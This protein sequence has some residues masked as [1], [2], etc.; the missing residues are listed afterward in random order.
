MR[1]GVGVYSIDWIDKLKLRLA[2]RPATPDLRQVDRVVWRL[3]FV[4]LLTDISAEMVNSA[5]PLY[6]V[7]HLHL[8]PLQ[9][10]VIDGLYNGF[11][12]AFL[13][14]AAGFVAD[15]TGRH[16]AMALAGYSISACCKLLL[17]LTGGAWTWI[18]LIVGIDRAG[19]GVR[20]APRDAMISAVTP[21]PLLASAFAVHRALDAG[22]SLL[23]PVAAFLL[24]AWLPGAFDALWTASFL[25]ALLGVAAL[26][27]FVDG[28]AGTAPTSARFCWREVRGLFSSSRYRSIAACG[29]LLALTTVSDGFL[30]LMLQKKCATPSGFLPLFYVITAC[31]YMAL[32]IP[33]GRVADRFGRRPVLLFGYALLATLYLLLMSVNTMNMAAQ[34]AFLGMLG[35]YYASTEGVL[36]AMAS[37]VIPLQVRGSGLALLV[38]TIAVAK[39]CSSLLFGWTMQTF[40][41]DV[42]A[43]AFAAALGSALIVTGAWLARPHRAALT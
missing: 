19:K 21:E 43:G 20:T 10:G 39:M 14:L 31:A 35:L 17:L 2:S 36:S 4:S 3:G 18:A 12:V 37:A 13:S 23:G 41:A 28:S 27:L 11:A 5:L 25:I 7:L 15:A 34:L 26:A 6:L 16:K 29:G 8:S 1:N 38:T 40:G 22:G 30:Y 24:L 9:Y 32:S 42:A 33:I